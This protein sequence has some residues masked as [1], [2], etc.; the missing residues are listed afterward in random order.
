MKKIIVLVLAV[1]MCLSLCA[2][3]TSKKCVKCGEEERNGN[4]SHNG[5]HY[6][7]SCYNQI[8]SLDIHCCEHCGKDT[9]NLASGRY[10][11]ESCDSELDNIVQGA[12]AK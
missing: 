9:E 3:E 2:C 6:C 12:L 10:R 1:V 4:K 7:Y 8:P 11:C 5:E